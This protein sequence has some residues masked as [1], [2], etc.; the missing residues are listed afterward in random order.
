MWP[1][2]MPQIPAS[3]RAHARGTSHHVDE[4]ASY[5][6]KLVAGM[7]SVGTDDP[8]LAAYLQVLDRALKDRRL[9]T[10]EADELRATADEW[11]IAKG[12]LAAAHQNYLA[13]LVTAARQDGEISDSESADLRRVERLLGLDGLDQLLEQNEPIGLAV[14]DDL[15]GASVCFTGE[16]QCRL[17]GERITRSLA[18]SLAADAGLDVQPRVTKGLDILVVA[19]PDTQSGKAKQAHARRTRIIA[20]R[21]FWEKLGVEVG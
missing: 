13:A 8:D 4:Q 17:A 20:E 14:R 12:A 16:L 3:G 19:D 9:T 1:A 18:A 10:A 11:G 5:L 7:P 21:A 6:A 15:A 2:A